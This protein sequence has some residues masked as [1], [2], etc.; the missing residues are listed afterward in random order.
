MA[1][2][3]DELCCMAGNEVEVLFKSY[4]GWWTI[5]YV[6]LGLMIANACI[7]V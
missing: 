4:S 7:K 5:R 1:R 3:S 2:Q 6:F